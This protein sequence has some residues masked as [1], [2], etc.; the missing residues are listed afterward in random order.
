M[1]RR[2]FLESAL[3]AGALSA[4]PRETLAALAPGARTTQAALF[5]ALPR[6]QTGDWV[7]LIMGAGVDYQKQIGAA[8]ETTE[9]GE[10]RYFE[11][12]VGTPGGSC[13]PNTMKRSYLQGAAFPSLFDRTAV[14]ANVANSGTTLTRWSDT[15]G[16]Q[17]VA[18]ADAKLQLL[19]ASYLYDDRP[20]R[21]VSSTPA[22]V[23]LPARGAY[24]G[25]A[26]ASR[27]RLHGVEATH[28]VA[29]FAPP[30]DATHRLQRIELW[31]SPAVPFGVVRYR[32][33]A[34]DLDPFELR[35]YAFGTRF[36]TD[37]AMSLQTIRSITPDGTHVQT[38]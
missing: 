21:I 3:A 33:I 24:A 17:T 38:S 4:L 29:T 1:Q 25:S 12:Q 23:A 30:S 7:R 13:N 27:G 19:D 6:P 8:V 22:T 35:L 14:V 5:A 11:T 20:L 36:K 16:G 18:P 31:T 10:L 15:A 28:T 32:A 2:H 9:Q 37:L 26:D 34:R